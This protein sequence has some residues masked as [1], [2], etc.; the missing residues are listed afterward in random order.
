[1]LVRSLPMCLFVLSL[2]LVSGC[3]KAKRPGQLPTKPVAVVV[4]YKGS[5]VEGATVTFIDT[6]GTAPAYGRT[7]AS[8]RA[9][10]K[11]Y[12]EGDGAILG[13]HKVTVAKVEVD[14][15][16]VADQDSADYNPNDLTP[17]AIKNVIPQKYASPASTDLSVEIS[18]SSPAELTLELKD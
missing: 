18:E 5:P 12:E 11:T 1:M 9:K 6:S 7:D 10:M 13:T 2:I 4:M 8:G 3:S 15:K 14:T 17:T 16:P